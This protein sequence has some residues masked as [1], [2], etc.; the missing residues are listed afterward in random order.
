[1]RD[2][3]HPSWDVQQ[4]NPRVEWIYVYIPVKTILIYKSIIQGSSKYDPIFVHE[5]DS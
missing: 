1:M 4:T 5:W 3:R 2:G